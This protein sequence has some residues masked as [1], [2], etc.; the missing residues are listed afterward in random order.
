MCLVVDIELEG[1]QVA[2]GSF[3]GE[4]EQIADAA[5]VASGGAGFV[6]DAVFSQDVVGDSGGQSEPASSDGR[7]PAR[8]AVL[9]NTWGLAVLGQRLLR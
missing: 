2:Q 5:H 7:G 4:T 8:V 3:D 6:E 9:R 1:G